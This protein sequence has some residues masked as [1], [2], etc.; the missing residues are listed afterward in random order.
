MVCNTTSCN[1]TYRLRYWNFGIS[2]VNFNCAHSVATAPTVYGIETV[3]SSSV[4][5][6]Y[7][8]SCNST[9]RLRYWNVPMERELFPSIRS[10]NSTYRLRYWNII[11]ELVCFKLKVLQQHL[12]FTVL[13]LAN[14]EHETICIKVC[15]NSTYRLRYWNRNIP[16]AVVRQPSNV[17]TAPTVYGIE[18]QNDC[19]NFDHPYCL[20]ATAPTVYGIE[21]IMYF[22]CYVV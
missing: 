9:Y 2:A 8:I 18:T 12:P 6:L 11:W 17:A 1:S 4:S 7:A 21:T 15:C 16:A 19:D 14:K 22:V 3:A 5:K 10:C 13:K 20:V